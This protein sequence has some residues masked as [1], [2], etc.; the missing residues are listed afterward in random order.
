MAQIALARVEQL[1]DVFVH[2]G[3]QAFD[4][5]TRAFDYRS[6]FRP[7]C[8]RHADTLGDD[9]EDPEPAVLMFHQ[10]AD[11]I[12]LVLGWRDPGVNLELTR[13]IQRLD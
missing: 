5:S 12:D 6:V 2:L 8:D 11:K 9:I 1:L 10:P 13:P 3:D 4:P 7:Q